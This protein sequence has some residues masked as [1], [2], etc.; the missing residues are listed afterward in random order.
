MDELAMG[1]PHFCFEGGINRFWAVGFAVGDMRVKW[2]FNCNVRSFL[3]TNSFRKELVRRLAPHN[4]LRRELRSLRREL[5]S[6]RR[7]L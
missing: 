1:L 2:G 5:R 6:I 7:E 4:S 3:P